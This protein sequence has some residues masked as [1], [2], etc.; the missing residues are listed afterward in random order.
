MVQ[1]WSHPK[2]LKPT[3]LPK[4][5]TSPKFLLVALNPCAKSVSRHLLML[6]RQVDSGGVTSKCYLGPLQHKGGDRCPILSL[7]W[8]FLY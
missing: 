5:F 1:L 6:W 2:A 3:F 4:T 7:M 8:F